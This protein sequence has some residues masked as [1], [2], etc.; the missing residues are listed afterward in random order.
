MIL[1]CR[2]IIEAK[3]GKTLFRKSI[4]DEILQVDDLIHSSAPSWRHNYSS[5]CGKWDGECFE[6]TVLDLGEVMG[7]I[8][9]G[10]LRV[11]YP[12]MFNPETFRTY[13][14]PLQF[15]GVKVSK[16]GLSVDRVQAVNLNYFLEPGTSDDLYVLF[17]FVNFCIGIYSRH[18][19]N[20]S[21]VYKFLRGTDWEQKIIDGIDYAKPF[22]KH[23]NVYLRTVRSDRL[24]HLAFMFDPLPYFLITFV[25]MM[26]FMA[27]TAMSSDCVRSKPYT[28]IMG[29]ICA[30]LG[31]IA[32]IGLINFCAYPII[33]MT[34]SVPFIM[35]G[36]LL[37]IAYLF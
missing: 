12:I 28:A 30:N 33:G 2:V 13:V 10:S 25:I 17:V 23:I 18:V 24:A 36:S 4:W 21:F 15:G 19:Y 34:T 7:Q 3:D 14:I 8:E 16:D 26:C 31:S 6:N 5:L 11:S 35:I 9:N 1:I 29:V 27:V 22:W 20:Y 32:G 37:C